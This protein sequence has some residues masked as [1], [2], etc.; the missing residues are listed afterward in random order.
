MK[1]IIEPGEDR[2]FVAHVPALKGCWSQGIT[3]AEALTNIRE[4]IE[5]WLETEQDKTEQPG[6]SLDVELVTV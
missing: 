3:R 4:A 1:V 5:A 2:G 6:D